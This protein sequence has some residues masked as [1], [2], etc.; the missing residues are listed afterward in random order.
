MSDVWESRF[1]A[2]A[3]AADALAPDGSG[4]TNRQKSAAGLDPFDARA[5]LKISALTRTADTVTLRWP[6]VAGKRYQVSSTSDPAAPGSAWQPLGDPVVGNGGEMQATFATGAGAT[7]A[8]YRVTVADLDSDN[9]GLSDWE[10]RQLGFDPYSAA[11]DGVRGDHA[12]AEAALQATASTVTFSASDSFASAAS[13]DPGSFT[14]HRS[15]RPEAITIALQVSGSA[16]AGTDFQP[17]PASVTLPFG[18]NA[19]TLRVVPLPNAAATSARTVVLSAAPGAD[20]T[21][22]TPAS[23]T[24]SLAPQPGTGAVLQEIWHGLPAGTVAAIPTTE[25]PATSRLLTT[26]E[27][28]ADDPGLGENYGTRIRGYLIPPVTGNYTFW[29]ASDDG[30]ELW[31]A[32]DDQPASLVKRAGFRRGRFRASGTGSRAR[33]R[34]C[35]RSSPARNIISKFCRPMPAAANI[36]RSAGCAPATPAPSRRRSSARQPAR[37]RR[38]SRPCGRRTARR[39]FSPASRPRAAWFRTAPAPRRCGSARTRHLP[40]CGRT[41]PV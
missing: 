10:E 12:R 35:S 29:I 32:N 19:A 1:H 14:V 28:P 7:R 39:C 37:W 9:D 6:S 18:V 15:G 5:V 23:A 22:G 13:A 30:S 34:R 8:F 33:N 38:S 11:T 2:S 20:Y 24:V 31:I 41:I 40:C 3:L 4:M 27:Q 36:S 26:L 17:L 16:T 21:V 25:P